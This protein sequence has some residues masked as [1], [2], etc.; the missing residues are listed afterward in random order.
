MQGRWLLLGVVTCVQAACGDG[1]LCQ[2]E[3][4][5]S[6][7]SSAI[8]VDVDP[9]APGV[10][11]DVRV[12][13]SLSRG[14]SVSLE[15]LGAD[16]VVLSTEH[17]TVDADG[18]AVFSVITVPSYRVTLRATGEGECGRGSDRVTLDVTADSPTLEIVNPDVPCGAALTPASDA[19]PALD[20]VQIVARVAAPGADRRTLAVSTASGTASFDVPG[21]GDLAV[22]LGPGESLLVG[23]GIDAEG[24]HHETEA[25]PLTLSDLSVSFAQPAANGTLG[26]KE[27]VLTGSSLALPVCGTVNRAGAS[28]EVALDGGAAV[29]ATV[30][31]TRWCIDL[32]LSESPPSHTIVATA[33]AGASFGRATLGV[34]VD[35]TAPPV[36]D[37]Y[38][39]TSVNRQ[40]IRAR[41]RSP[42]DAG[43]PVASYV[44]KFATTALTEANFDTTGTVIPTAVPVAVGA[45][46]AV[47]LFPARPG[48]AYW[49][50]IATFDAAGNRSPAR[51]EGP[52]TPGFDR[53][54]AIVAPDPSQGALNLGYAIAHGKF[55]D[56]ELED[57]AI[58]APTQDVAGKLKAGA[59]YVYFGGASVIGATPDLVLTGSVANG[60]FGSGLATVRWSSAT[61]DDLAVGAPGAG[62]G[63]LRVFRG[64]AAFGTGTRDATTADLAITVDATSPGFFA[65]SG[66]GSSVVSAD[67]DGDGL[68]DLVAAAPSGGGKG[69]VVVLYGGTVTT[70]VALS[71]LDPGPAGG[72][73]CEL[74]VDPGATPGR[75]LGFYL[76]AV[77]P[78][79]GPTDLTDDLVVAYEDDYLTANDSLFVLRGDGARPTAPGV[80]PRAFAIG[81]DV[82]IDFATTSQITE[83]GSQVTSIDDQ[84]GDGARDMV[85]SAFR[86][87][88]STGQ[89]LIVSGNVVGTAGVA[90]TSDPGIKLTTITGTSNARFGVFVVGNDRT[91]GDLDGDGRQDLVIGGAPGNLG[92]AFV[93]FGGA[94]PTGSVSLTTAQLTIQAPAPFTFARQLPKGFAG[95]A[96]WV[97]D[98]DGDGLE[99]LCWASPFDNAG[100]GSFEVLSD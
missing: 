14:E 99:D 33:T 59:V 4:F 68:L 98:L 53:T 27:G 55:N 37:D 67:V 21:D 12:R 81:R 100:D 64:G 17:T 66:L 43:Q 88:G 45:D 25:C 47:D 52:L 28:V 41:W 56:D 23:T 61:R 60:R 2:S 38:V 39:V 19:D 75:H 85:I 72:A 6:V 13:T 7:Q 9:A 5:V 62:S 77:G 96:R 73:I 54:G 20:G 65:N 1:P 48:T 51:I 36:V 79:E 69:G 35:L 57:L 91:A 58:A 97:G 29:D 42:D 76:H 80:S 10:Q 16:D 89:A 49:V 83:F 90:R 24:N 18:N 84:N 30:T 31:G 87:S 71:D 8:L 50:A 74:F 26:R 70:D 82:Q 3:V 22:T 11:A 92:K 78:T 32:T 94:I 86:L 15:V 95:Q 34:R 44:V 46:E 93:W 63:E 40:R